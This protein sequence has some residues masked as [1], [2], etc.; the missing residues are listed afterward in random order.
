MNF[1]QAIESLK[2]GSRVAREGWNGKGMWLELQRPTPE[3]KMTL[4]YIYMFT[5]DKNLV[6][7]LASQTDI[8]AED[9]TI[10]EVPNEKKLWQGVIMGELSFD[11]ADCIAQLNPYTAI[12]RPNW[13]G[14]HYYNNVGERFV[15][16]GN[17]HIEKVARDSVYDSGKHDW[18]VVR[19]TADAVLRISE[20]ILNS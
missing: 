15:L 11:K 9:W 19:L 16:L 7:W 18:C 5:A 1:G 6:P 12:T 13:K 2:N 17:G 14:V 4:P 3:S 8:L 20:Y 10:V